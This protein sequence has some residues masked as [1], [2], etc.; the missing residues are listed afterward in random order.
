MSK[1]LDIAGR[2]LCFHNRWFQDSMRRFVY[3]VFFAVTLVC[4]TPAI[5]YAADKKPDNPAFENAQV[6]VRV[7]ARTPNQMAAFY[8]GRGFPDRAIT[9]ITEACFITVIVHNKTSDVLWLD[10]AT[11]QFKGDGVN[12]QRL[13]R[14]YWQGQWERLDVPQANRA[15]FRWTLL[16]EKRDLRVDEAVGGNITLTQTKVPFSIRMVFP[17]KADRSGI[18]VVAELNDIKC[19]YD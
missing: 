1:P 3:Y 8:E 17:T 2:H 15:T 6:K 13:E 9:Q 19:N 11:W 12:T 7:I 5:L 10:L 18:E 16:P 14:A 4:L